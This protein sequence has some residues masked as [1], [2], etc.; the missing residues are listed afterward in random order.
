MESRTRVWILA[1]EEEVDDLTMIRGT[2]VVEEV[3][4]SA[5]ELS[6]SCTLFFTSS[7]FTVTLSVVVTTVTVDVDDATICCCCSPPPLP[8]DPFPFP[9]SYRYASIW[10]IP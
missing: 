7:T 6:F 9:T 8:S 5:V 3:V 10:F 1:A 2:G 4:S